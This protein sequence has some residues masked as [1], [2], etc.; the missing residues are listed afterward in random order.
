MYSVQENNQA[1]H[2]D[3]DGQK[4]VEVAKSKNVD[5]NGMVFRKTP[6]ANPALFVLASSRYLLP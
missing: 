1:K 3:E 2:S 5:G 6:E 4:I